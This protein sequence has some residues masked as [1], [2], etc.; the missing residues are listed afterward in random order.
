MNYRGIYSSLE[1]FSSSAEIIFIETI[2]FNV[3]KATL[4]Y[5]NVVI[6]LNEFLYVKYILHFLALLGL[7]CHTIIMTQAC[8][9]IMFSFHTLYF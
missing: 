3:Y 8:G 6:K 4:I 1:R 7:W 5:S 2:A 9:W